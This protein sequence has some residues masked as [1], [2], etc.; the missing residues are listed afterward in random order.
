MGLAAYRRKRSF[1]HTSEPRGKTDKRQR[2]QYVILGR[3]SIV[4]VLHWIR[5][6]LWPALK[7]S[8]QRWSSD[9]GSLHSA[10]LAY[11]AA[12]SLFP[13]CLTL[14]AALGVVTTI[15]GEVQDRQRQMLS[16]VRENIGPWLADQLQVILLTVKG[17]ATIGGT[18]GILTLMVA[19]L[20]MF[21]QLETMFGSVWKNSER[22]TY[23]WRTALW[24]ILYERIVAFF[25]LL[26]VSVL[27][28]L[29][30]AANMI[31]SGV[32]FFDTRLS[33]N[34]ATWMIVQW[35]SAISGNTALLALVFR[36][37]PRAPI[38][39]KEALVGG[40][41]AA[42]ILQI[43]QHFLAMF[44][45]GDYYSVYGVVGSF[46]AVMVWFYYASAVV[47]FGAEVV[48]ALGADAHDAH[49]SR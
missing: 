11:Y 16:L 38:R 21:V 28:I 29:L 25:M 7:T 47:F 48:R 2:W 18:L 36:T 30:F 15:F 49:A 41:L 43:G 39:W 33:L 44:V 10:A 4:T 32:K 3:N 46:I 20:G 13:L 1:G 14:I 35:L 19:A 42:F 22:P 5:S 12:F 23:G 24:T 31:L 45:I 27:V 9:G 8:A 26:G 40:L 17:Q 34:H 6:Q 37:I